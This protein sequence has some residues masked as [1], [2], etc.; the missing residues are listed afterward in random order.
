MPAQ[1]PFQPSIPFAN[2]T[3]SLSGIQ[4]VI[5]QAWNPRDQALDANGVPTSDGAWYFDVSDE[6]GNPIRVGIK[7]VL[8]AILAQK[9]VDP[10]WPFGVFIAQDTSGQGKEAGLD[11][12]GTR[13]V[14]WFYTAAEI[15]QI[16]G[17]A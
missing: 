6:Q 13:V 8:G 7:I 11:D 9:T 16:W 2:F 1:I 17:L 5:D 3:V 15:A 4:Y 10:R 14:V 12:I